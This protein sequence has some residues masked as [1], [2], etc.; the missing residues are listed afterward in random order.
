LTANA[1][2]RTI[3]YLLTVLFVVSANNCV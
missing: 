1:N 3:Q 2:F